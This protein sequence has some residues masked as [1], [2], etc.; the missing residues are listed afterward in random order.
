MKM[1]HQ[2]LLYRMRRIRKILA[3]ICM[4]G[5]L[6]LIAIDV[7]AP[8]GQLASVKVVVEQGGGK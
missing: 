2:H 8:Q 3:I 1:T 4:Y 5:L 7:F 6:A